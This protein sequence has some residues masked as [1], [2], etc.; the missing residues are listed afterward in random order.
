MDLP[1]SL[2]CFGGYVSRLDDLLTLLQINL[3][4][5]GFGSLLL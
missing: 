1:F 2:E 5:L 4:I 3:S